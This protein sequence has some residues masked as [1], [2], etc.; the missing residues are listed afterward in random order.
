VIKR[1]A[2]RE[3]LALILEQYRLDTHGIHGVAHWGR[4]LE[5][6][7]RLCAMTGGDPAVI[8]MFSLF[9]DAC[10]VR[11]S[12]DANHGPRAAELA[13]RF[14][15]RLGLDDTQ[16]AELVTACQGHTRGPG[17]DADITVLT[18]L[19]ADR[20]DIPRVGMAIKPDLLFTGAGRSLEML[21]WAGRRAADLILPAVCADEWGWHP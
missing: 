21:S 18:C 16:F 15:E 5:N 2:V 11:D 20:L 7:R 10:R 8:E 4:V 9:H 14:R 3:I 6:G 12:W 1:P 17:E 19:D 13:R